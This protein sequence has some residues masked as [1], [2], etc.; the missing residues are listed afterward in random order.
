MIVRSGPPKSARWCRVEAR[1][2]QKVVEISCICS[3]ASRCKLGK[4]CLLLGLKMQPRPRGG[5]AASVI[6]PLSTAHLARRIFQQKYSLQLAPGVIEWLESFVANFEMEDDEEQIVS[7]FEHLVRGCIG[8]GSGLGKFLSSLP[9]FSRLDSLTET[10]RIPTQQTDPARLPSRYSKRRMRNC[11]SPQIQT[12]TVQVVVVAAPETISTHPSTSRS[13]IRSNCLHGDG[14]TCEGVSRGR[15]PPL[16]DFA[17]AERL[18]HLLIPSSYPRIR[19]KDAPSIAPGPLSKSRYLRDRFNIIKQVILRN[20]HFCPPTVVDAARSDYMKVGAS[21]GHVNQRLASDTRCSTQLTT[22][23]NLLGRQGGHFLLFGLLTRMEDNEFYLEDL[24]DKVKLDLS[25]AV[26]FTSPSLRRAPAT[27]LT[28]DVGRR[29]SRACSPKVVS[30]WSTATLATTRSSKWQK[31]D[32][33]LVSGAMKPCMYD[34]RAYRIT[35]RCLD[36]AFPALQENPRAS[37]F[38]RCRCRLGGRRGESYFS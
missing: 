33:R 4:S 13:L 1:V 5:R 38:S 21:K 32:I 31:S 35:N 37:R 25:E 2:D 10:L 16:A 20:E 24:D 19:P 3:S 17:L 15:F 29:P 7:T 28:S 27:M 12:R 18:Q 23:K 6:T 9:L 8:S 14:T 34:H 11:S 30:S 22:I 36:N 26:S